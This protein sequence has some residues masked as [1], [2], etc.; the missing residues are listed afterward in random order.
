MSPGSA[1]LEVPPYLAMAPTSR[2][3]FA[4]L[5]ARVRASA[6][7]SAALADSFP[8]STAGRAGRSAG[9]LLSA[10]EAFGGRPGAGGG[11]AEEAAASRD[12]PNPQHANGCALTVVPPQEHRRE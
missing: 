4:A 3:R 5:A 6:A 12:A 2:W 11:A 9:G 7:R 1:P 10:G 8:G